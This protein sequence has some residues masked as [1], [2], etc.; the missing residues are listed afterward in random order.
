[1]T[2]RRKGREWF[3]LAVG[4]R[5][6]MVRLDHGCPGQWTAVA[7]AP[8][9]TGRA[10]VAA[11]SAGPF[12][13]PVLRLLRERLGGGPDGEPDGEHRSAGRVPARRPVR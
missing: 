10:R 5:T 8:S 4:A 11:V 1:V 6:Y 9:A 12:R 13:A 2:I 3:P 7:V